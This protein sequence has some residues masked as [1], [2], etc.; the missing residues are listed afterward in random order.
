VEEEPAISS[1]A[2]TCCY[3]IPSAPPAGLGCHPALCCVPG[4]L[5][6]ASRSSSSAGLAGAGLAG[7]RQGL[8][9]AVGQPAG[10]TARPACPQAAAAAGGTAQGTPR[11][12]KSQ[13]C[14][15]CMLLVCRT[16]HV[17]ECAIEE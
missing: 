4:G 8:A 5:P 11:G 2:I 13:I 3:S 15:L 17:A 14:M 6:L 7:S 16:Y 10:C 12:E 1:H 9:G